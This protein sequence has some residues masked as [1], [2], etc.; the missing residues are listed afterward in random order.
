V[1]RASIDIPR[2]SRVVVVGSVNV[3]LVGRVPA[4][5][6]PGET[7]IGPGVERHGGGKG[8]NAAVAA[9]RLGAEVALVAAVGDDGFGVEA[10]AEL[11]REG[12]DVSA[13]LT[14]ADVPTGA[15]LIVV[16]GAGENQIAVGAGAN[17]ALTPEHVEQALAD[18]LPGCGCLVVGTEIPD[19]CVV[20][21][22]R[23]AARAGVPCVLNPAPARPSVLDAA[24]AGPILTPNA[25]EARMLAQ[26]ADA[27]T[28][29]DRAGVTGAAAALGALTGQPVIVTLGA[30]GALLLAPGRAPVRVPSHPAPVV[31]TTGAGDAFNGALATRLAAG[32]QVEEAVRYAVVAAGL[33]V[34]RPGARGGM[35]TRDE[36]ARAAF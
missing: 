33:S 30:E 5:P 14:L 27:A 13:V 35:P 18:R 23:A 16:D 29:D 7:V 22:V 34:A 1:A 3:D 20:A 4:L 21:A 28:R 2:V 10:R 6:A 17:F 24:A 32:A 26:A 25:G 9:A 11:E 12:V 36:V 19:A 31:D 8:A 15:A